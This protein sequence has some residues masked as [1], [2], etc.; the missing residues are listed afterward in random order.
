M[1][2]FL[3]SFAVTLC[4]GIALFGAPPRV[5]TAWDVIVFG[6]ATVYSWTYRALAWPFRALYRLISPQNESPSS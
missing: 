4:L 3:I 1:E 2:L 6:V 5:E